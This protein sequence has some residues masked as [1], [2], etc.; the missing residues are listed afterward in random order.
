[1]AQTEHDYLNDRL[2]EQLDYHSKASKEN[3]KKFYSLQFIIILTSAL[4]PI[5]NVVSPAGDALRLISSILGGIIV[6][7]TS[8][9]QL[10]KYHENWITFRS[11][12]ELLKREKYLYLNDAGEYA[13]IEPEK[14]KRLLV[15]NTESIV[16]SETSRYFTIHK[17]DQNKIGDSSGDKGSNT[18]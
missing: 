16:S 18:I 13:N 10:H 1:M 9:M 6:V 11:T 12:Q 4:I 17:A 14:K 15:E 8:L 3:K 5:V 7:S 2:Q